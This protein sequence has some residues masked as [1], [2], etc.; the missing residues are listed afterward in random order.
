MKKFYANAFSCVVVMLFAFLPTAVSAQSFE[1]VEYGKSY[2]ISEANPVYLTI[3]LSSPGTLIVKQWGTSDSHIFTTKD[4]AYIDLAV[5]PDG[6]SSNWEGGYDLPY[7][8][9]SGIYYFIAPFPYDDINE[10]II[11]FEG[12]SSDNIISLGNSFV[13][14][15]NVPEWVFESKEKGI[16]K[17]ST[18][19][20]G[21]L[22]SNSHFLFNDVTHVNPLYS[23]KNEVTGQGSNYFFN[24]DGNSVYYFKYNSSPDV[25]FTFEM[26]NNATQPVTLTGIYPEPGEAFSVIDYQDGFQMI[27]NPKRVTFDNITFSYTPTGSNKIVTE[28]V[29]N[30]RMVGD[31]TWR[32]EIASLYEEAVAQANGSNC[33]ITVYGV[34]YE[35]SPLSDTMVEG[36]VVENGNFSF[37]YLLASAPRLVSSNVPDPFYAYW[38]AGNPNSIATFTFDQPIKSAADA[39]VIYAHAVPN[40]PTPGDNAPISYS[41]KPVINGN[42]VSYDFSGPHYDM[43]GK[44]IP[45]YSYSGKEITLFISSVQAETGLFADF[46]GSINYLKYISFLNEE[47]PAGENPPAPELPEATLIS[48]VPGVS[49]M[50]VMTATWD[51][52]PLSAGSMKAYL[53]LPDGETVEYKGK[54]VDEDPNGIGGTMTLASE[55]NAFMVQFGAGYTSPGTYILTIPAGSVLVNGVENKEVSFTY[56]LEGLSYMSYAENIGSTGK[57]T[58]FFF[59][60]E[61]TWDYQ[62]IIANGEMY[63]ELVINGGQPQK[64]DGL[65]LVY[66]DP[67]QQ[68]GN[69]GIMTMAE[70]TNVLVISLD[71]IDS[72]VKG[73]YE[74]IIPE[75]IV[76]NELNE[77]NPQQIFTYYVLDSDY[78]YVLTPTSGSEIPSDAAV[79]EVEWEGYK[80]LS[81]NPDSMNIFIE[82]KERTYLYFGENVSIDGSILKIDISELEDGTY[83]LTVPEAYVILGNEASFNGEI[84]ATYTLVSGTTVVNFV[85]IDNNGEY[86]VYNTKGVN[87]LNTK[88]SEDLKKL[89]RGIYII[90]GKSVVIR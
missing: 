6:Y 35:G 8:L 66:F 32:V 26:D 65:S 84:Y 41:V 79:I 87:V 89:S 42:T 53:T 78:N 13:A 1:P 76:V 90:N 46:D 34:K 80:T 60:T 48:P 64:I 72:F 24:I 83:E 11:Q 88:D 28:N 47:G 19:Y 69:P 52:E 54:I 23:F 82:S 75:G 45:P 49:A 36:T 25:T 38:S 50:Y 7:E 44:E 9:T 27:F 70:E 62:N 51:Y 18:D 77:V 20:K 40:A 10:A 43:D 58:Q 63:A 2:Q 16:L 85:N 57:Y 68:G 29:T 5:S 21:D 74:L 56:E 73:V 37:E 71:N 86:R 12:F 15:T 22:I 14:G 59:G 17:V 61:I 67:D 3:E 31:D 33:K 30:Y 55:D 81:Y 39:S 4:P